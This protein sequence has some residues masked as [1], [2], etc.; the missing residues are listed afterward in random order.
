MRVIH[1][2][3]LEPA[4]VRR[5]FVPTMGALH[6]GH[7]ALMREARNLVGPRGEVVVSIFVNPTQFGAGEDFDSYPRD[8]DRDVLVC[9]DEGVDVVYAP[10]AQGVYGSVEEQGSRITLDPGPLGLVWEGAHR[11]GHFA[12]VL[13][14]VSILLHQVDPDV[15][16][17]GEKDYQQLELVRRM[18][19]D[20]SFGV[21]IVGVPTVRD[22]DGLALSSRNANLDP[23]ERRQASAVP[24]AL[25]AAQQAAIDGAQASL[26][27]VDNVLAE[28][29][30]VPDYRA[31]CAPDLG[32]APDHGGARLLV[33]VPVGRTRLIDNCTVDLGGN[34]VR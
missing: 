1:D 26:S 16:L 12:G 6:D 29:G 22:A 33:A 18:C 4:R 24:H 8:L 2:E 30:L 7:R 3:P 20:L 28:A 23:E 27:A 17:F 10:S 15:A 32:P 13:T 5:A 34:D 19:R 11:P 9:A 14:V 25:E 31:L 21:E